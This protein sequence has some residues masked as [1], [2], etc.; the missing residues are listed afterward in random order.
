MLTLPLFLPLF[1]APASAGFT[2]GSVAPPILSLPARNPVPMSG[3]VTA[4]RPP[5][6]LAAI[7][8]PVTI[9]FGTQYRVTN[10]PGAQNE[11]SIAVNPT[12][13]LNIVAMANDYRGG[14]AWCGVYA[15]TNGGR[16]WLEQ[17]LPRGGGLTFLEASGDPSV[18]FD[19]AGNAY[20]A[21]LGFNRSANPGNAITVS[22]SVDGG[23]TWGTPVEVA[24]TTSGVFHDKSYIVTDRSNRPTRGNV[25]VTWTR[26]VAGASPIYFS[27]STDGGAS[28]SPGVDITS[29]GY[30]S[31]QGSQ[32][33]VGPDGEL[34]VSFWATGSR[35]ALAR[36]T[37][38]GTTWRP[39]T[40]VATM[41]DP[42]DL[43]PAPGPRTPHFPTIAV[44]PI[45]APGGNRVHVAWA[46]RR[47]GDA[48]ILMMTSEDGGVTWGAVVRVNDDRG[49]KAQFFPFLTASEKGFVHVAFYDRRDDPLD[50]LLTV[51][52]ASSTDFGVTFGNR[53]A[54]AQFGA[55]T[56]FIGD[57]IGSASHGDFVYAGWCDL[58][59]A[60]EEEVYMAG[61]WLSVSRPPLT[62]R[63]P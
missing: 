17:L 40:T 11:V 50:L 35:V 24:R 46:D 30:K 31:D 42:G 20:A 62:V 63:L 58:R 6:A 41:F 9:P 29:L 8:D 21:C 16:T 52:I 4:G 5:V 54:S 56:W 60:G 33:A 55:G 45:A 10:N 19:G 37:D 57:Y 18:A 47:F 28:F 44:N 53:R 26:F 22:K 59:N 23:V 51:Y 27:R 12:N 15:T 7:T 43:Y 61:P 36:S 39:T 13:P 2:D 3:V 25:Y 34:F 14:D 48:D 1:A 49:G 32:P 38:G